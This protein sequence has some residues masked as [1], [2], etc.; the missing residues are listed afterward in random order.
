MQA[1]LTPVYPVFNVLGDIFPVAISLEE[2]AGLIRVAV[3]AEGSHVL[4]L[5]EEG[6]PRVAR[7]D[8]A[9]GNYYNP[10]ALA[11]LLRPKRL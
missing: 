9:F 5:E 1:D 10:R 6:L 8:L 2:F 3:S 4:A 11:G 7:A